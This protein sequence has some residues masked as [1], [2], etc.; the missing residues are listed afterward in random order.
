VAAYTVRARPGAPVST[1][2][3]WEELS[4]ALRP[5]DFNMTS[6]PAR[7]AG[8]RADPWAAYATTRQ[9]L[10]RAMWRALGAE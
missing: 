5:A 6:V 2:L 9:S 10:T 4:P 3:A 1:P 8:L 7:L